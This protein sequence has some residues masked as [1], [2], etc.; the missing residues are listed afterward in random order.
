MPPPSHGSGVQR[1]LDMNRKLL[2]AILAQ[3]R[4]VPAAIACAVTNTGWRGVTE[5]VT[6]LSVKLGVVSDTA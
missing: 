4:A 2:L 1:V 3:I 6:I 5:H